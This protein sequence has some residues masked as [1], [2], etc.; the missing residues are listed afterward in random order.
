MDSVKTYSLPSLPYDYNA[1]EP[2]ISTEIMTLHHSKHHATYVKNLNAALAK[3]FGQIASSSALVD[4]TALLQVVK[5]NAGGHI[6]H[7]LFWQN[8][9]PPN[10]AATDARATAPELVN[11]LAGRYKSLEG[12]R[13][14]FQASMLSLQG[15]GWCWLVSDAADANHL[16]IIQ[17]RDQDPV[18]IHYKP[19][20]G[21]DM[22][23]HAYYLQYRNN[24][25]DYAARI[26]EVVNWEV[27]ESRYK[28][29]L[30]EVYTEELWGLSRDG[31]H[32]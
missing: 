10:T 16:D 5:F 21:I 7:S 22:W 29:G 11:A 1:L 19:L 15:S 8:L 4:H 31:P 28:V 24:K 25:A 27:V 13:Q 12:F 30:K 9:A 3:L 18:P 2:I 23:E 17:T 20:L 26:W 32:M 6:N 14:A